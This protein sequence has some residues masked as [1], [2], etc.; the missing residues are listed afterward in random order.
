MNLPSQQ[1]GM[2][3]S[4]IMVVIMLVAV[5]AKLGL[6]ILP[7]QIGYYQLKKSLAHALKQ[8]NDNQESAQAF[9]SN[10]G[11]Q[12]TIDGVGQQPEDVVTVI[13]NTPGALAVS[14]R[15]QE[16]RNLFGQVDVVNRFED[17][18][19]AEDAKTANP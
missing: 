6:A 19:T 3:V 4:G 8:A 16:T 9:M 18:I 1:R 7:A 12:W 2:S 14:L 13:S 10:V 5:C 15:Y 11:K 17:T